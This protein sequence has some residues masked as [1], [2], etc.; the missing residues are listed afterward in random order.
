MADEIICPRCKKESFTAA[1]YAYLPC[2]HC[3]QSFSMSGMDKRFYPRVYREVAFSLNVGSEVASAKTIDISRDGLGIA[4]T[5]THNIPV[6]KTLNIYVPELGID[7]KGEV[8]WQKVLKKETSSETRM[9]I[10][11]H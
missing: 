6:G 7:S 3:G 10:R 11:F 1:P 5:G 9:G 4:V 8:V 2:P